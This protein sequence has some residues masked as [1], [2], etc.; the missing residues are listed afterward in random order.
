MTLAFG[1]LGGTANGSPPGAPITNGSASTDE[2][3]VALAHASTLVC[4]GT[5]IAPHA[6][7]TAGHC[8]DS[9][10]PEIAIGDTLATA[11]RQR[12][13]AV[14][15]HP[16][17]DPASLDH[18]IAIVIVDPPL[19]VAPR[20]FATS[21]VV[22]VGSMMRIVGYGWTV[23]NDTSPAVRRTGTSQIDTIDELRITSHGAPSQA[24]E[25]DSGGPALFDAGSGE[26]V[27][28]VTSSG[29]E[30]CT[31]F[32]RHTRVDVHADF[33]TDIVARTSAG[34]AGAGDRCW[35]DANCSIGACLPAIDDDRL[36]FCAPSCIG[37][38]PDDLE[39][40]TVGGDARCRHPAPSP[41]AEGSPCK[42]DSE[43]AGTLC[44]APKGSSTKV[45]TTRCF[46]DL[47]NFTCPGDETCQAATDL[48]EACFAKPDDG[49][50]SATHSSDGSPVLLLLALVQLLRG[51]GRP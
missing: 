48:G 41:G 42:S 6:I 19:A 18:D 27:I 9:Q 11:T 10:L 12:A 35:Y 37:G 29:D 46:S 20:P 32:A 24:C 15:P 39:C 45:C 43:C 40:I 17:F 22:N 4:T 14:F 33:V 49:W 2:A 1:A 50:C 34:G 26:L 7:L 47:P 13:L 23:A 28:G 25:G 5:V 3:V 36:S 31:Q 51:R 30:T 21:L 44:L 8:L 16:D 38:C